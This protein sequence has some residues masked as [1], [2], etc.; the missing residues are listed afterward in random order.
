VSAAG[1]VFPS[2]VVGAVAGASAGSLSVSRLLQHAACALEQAR[3]DGVAL[4]VHTGERL[5]RP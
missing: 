3:R 2:R 4:G 5:E 1:R